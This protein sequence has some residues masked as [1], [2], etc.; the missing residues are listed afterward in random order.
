MRTS[1]ITVAFVF[2]N[3]FLACSGSETSPIPST[4]TD[5]GSNSLDSG[6][7]PQP[8]SGSIA[9]ASDRSD[10][11]AGVDNRIDPIAL[12]RS[13][14][15]DVSIIGIY[16]LCKSGSQ[17]GAVLSDKPVGGMSAF[18]VQS[19]C[20]GV[21]VNSYHVEED[22]VEVYYGSQWVLSLDA[23]VAEG[24]EWTDGL[25]TYVWARVGTATVPAGT[26]TDCW[27]AKHK[28]GVNYTRFCRGVGPIKW[29]YVDGT[30]NGY[31][32]VLTTF[33]K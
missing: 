13:W 19:F 10:A 24:H 29:H 8:D 17:T 33:K 3:I 11:D 14:T 25:F 1:S 6:T 4:N 32:A 7:S 23:P 2:T 30:G 28:G 27:D 15:Y 21:G 20:P 26:F 12:G 5:G 16:P 22:R 9:D 18:Q 31:D